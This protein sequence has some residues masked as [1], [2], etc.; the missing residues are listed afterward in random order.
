MGPEATMLSEMSQSESQ[1]LTDLT[2]TCD[3]KQMTSQ[4]ETELQTQG[5]SRRL[6]EGNECR[7]KHRKEV[8]RY[9]LLAAR[10]TG[11]SCTIWR[12]LSMSL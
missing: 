1:T 8:K 12:I 11:M 4:A 6:P 2:Y 10:V 7:Q 9:Q 5:M 3:Q